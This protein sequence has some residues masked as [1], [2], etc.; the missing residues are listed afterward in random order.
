MFL[1]QDPDVILASS[2]SVIQ[3]ERISMLWLLPQYVL[4]TAGEVLF[5]ITSLSFSFTQAPASMK[6]V[7]QALFLLTTAFGDLIDVVVMSAVPR[8]AFGGQAGE[9][10]FFAALMFADM[11]ALA[12]LAVRYRY[13]DY[14]GGGDIV[15]SEVE[16]KQD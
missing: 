7:L 15:G 8:G 10:L 1:L 12:A 9:F 5:S 6:A 4:V 16:E 14:T 11:L 13:V 2:E 3:A